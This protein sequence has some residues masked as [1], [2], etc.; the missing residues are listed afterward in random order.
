M[1]KKLL[2][3]ALTFGLVLVLFTG[4]CLS[5]E[6]QNATCETPKTCTK[7]DKTEGE[8]LGHSWQEATC[9]TARTCATCG[10]TEGEALGHDVFWSTDD[11]TNMSGL[12]NTCGAS[13]QEELDWAQLGPCAVQRNW[14][15]T[16]VE[17][18]ITVNGDGTAHL[19]LDGKEY[20]MTWEFDTVQESM[21]GEMVIFWFTEEDGTANK[22]V[23]VTLIGNMFMLEVDNTVYTFT[24]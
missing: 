5:H 8:A 6:W 23:L 22:G 13:F 9:E 19:T 11:R 3:L 16:D 21:M 7:C 24:N 18:N 12:C 4:C 1:N 17:G 20:A 14:T 2:S 15:C 10:V